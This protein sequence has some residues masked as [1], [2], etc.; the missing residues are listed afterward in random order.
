MM[1]YDTYITSLVTCTYTYMYINNNLL[2]SQ[3]MLLYIV[4]RL[5]ERCDPCNLCDQ[6]NRSVAEGMAH[7]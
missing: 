3:C 2:T 6:V 1:Y 7:G 4:D 5:R